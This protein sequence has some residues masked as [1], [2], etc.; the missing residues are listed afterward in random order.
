[1]NIDLS[2]IV[3][4]LVTNDSEWLPKFC[5]RLS[6]KKTRSLR[7]SEN[8]CRLGA[9]IVSLVVK[10]IIYLKRGTELGSLSLAQGREV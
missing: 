5:Y 2:S 10:M 3:A 6:R 8:L 7:L 4:Y 9:P 1:M